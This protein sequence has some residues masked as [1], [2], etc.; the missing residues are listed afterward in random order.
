MG[1]LTPGRI[2]PGTTIRITGEFLDT[3][4]VD[5]DPTVSIKFKLRSPA[6]VETT[7]VYGTDA[8][9]QKAST[10][11]YTA[12]VTPDEGG[13]WRY[14]WEATSVDGSANTFRAGSEGSF[15]V[16]VSEFDGY[17]GSWGNDYR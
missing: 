17:T 7:Y 11:N 3:D 12:D 16:T 13:R 5:T 1:L 15:V 9:L 8:A 10:G 4:D 6:N 2:Y 14:R